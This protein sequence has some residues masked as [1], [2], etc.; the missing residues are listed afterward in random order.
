MGNTSQAVRFAHLIFGL[1][2]I[3]LQTHLT[4]LFDKFLFQKTTI[5]V[6]LVLSFVSTKIQEPWIQDGRCDINTWLHISR[7]VPPL[8]FTAISTEINPVI[9]NL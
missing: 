5:F 2:Y 7:K 1:I 8:P 6:I 3:F 4:F 9:M